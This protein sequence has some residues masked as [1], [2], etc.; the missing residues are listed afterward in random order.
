M[1]N[2]AVLYDDKS[3]Q[4]LAVRGREV[5]LTSL[6]AATWDPGKSVPCWRV[7]V[8]KYEIYWSAT[9]GF[10]NLRNVVLALCDEITNLI[11]EHSRE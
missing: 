7:A 8:G 4:M 10:H 2:A 6:C 1:L 3:A 11:P 5:I 9:Y